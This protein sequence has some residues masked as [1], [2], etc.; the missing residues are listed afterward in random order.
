MSGTRQKDIER[1]ERIAKLLDSQ[2]VVPGTGF[3]FGLDGLLGLI[4]GV[5]DT[6]TAVSTAYLIGM[7]TQLDMPG[8][9]KARMAWNGLLDW[10][11]GLIPFFGDLFDF[12]FKA[13]RKNV[14]LILSE[15]KRRGDIIEGEIVD[16]SVS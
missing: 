9:V 2:F 5:G 1:L 4:P 8:H 15:L 12:A 13:N 14:N 7:A 10:L 3:R 6:M 11:V 16:K